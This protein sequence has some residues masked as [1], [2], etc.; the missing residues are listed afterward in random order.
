MPEV[1]Q[2]DPHRPQRPAEEERLVYALSVA[3][4]TWYTCPRGHMERVARLT[5]QLGQEFGFSGRDLTVLRHGGLLHDLG[6][7]GVSESVLTKPSAL[8]EV[9]F[10]E[11]RQH[12]AIGADILRRLG[13]RPRTRALVLQH[14]EWYDG[15]GYPHGLAGE[16]I[17]FGARLLAVADA[18]DAMTSDRPYR[19]ARTRD[20]ALEEIHLRSGTQF[21]PLVVRALLELADEL[22]FPVEREESES[23]YPTG[24]VRHGSSDEHRCGTH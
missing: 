9:E 15:R 11:L 20:E 2:S 18:F 23:P 19:K 10:A 3:A 6:K 4:E 12:P 8:S 22:P 24:E 13:F 21:D 17:E 7:L 5:V 16:E 14:H 1:A